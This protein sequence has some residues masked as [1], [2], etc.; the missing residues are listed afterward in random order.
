MI[1][2]RIIKK[3]PGDSGSLKAFF[4]EKKPC[5][6]FLTS[7]LLLNCSLGGLS[8]MLFLC[9]CSDIYIAYKSGY[10]NNYF[11]F[12]SFTHKKSSEFL[13]IYLFSFFF[14]GKK[15]EFHRIQFF[16]FCLTEVFC[17]IIFCLKWRLIFPEGWLN[18]EFLD[19]YRIHL[20]KNVVFYM[21]EPFISFRV[22]KSWV[23][24][25]E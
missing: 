19:I 13:R 3:A 2:F 4:N 7:L 22:Y 5:L 9:Y 12:Y 10:V 15:W 6:L 20:Q 16:G 23:N 25:E 8:I 18:V 24:K 11:S 21:S 17:F 14:P 1:G